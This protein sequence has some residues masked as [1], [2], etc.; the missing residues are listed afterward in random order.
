MYSVPSSN[1]C[2]TQFTSLPPNTGV[3]LATHDCFQVSSS[4]L[5]APNTFGYPRGG[6]NHVEPRLRYTSWAILAI[7]DIAGPKPV[8]C[9]LAVRSKPTL[10][11]IRNLRVLWNNPLRATPICCVYLASGACADDR[12]GRRLVFLGWICP[13]VFTLWETRL[14]YA[15]VSRTEYCKRPRP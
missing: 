1:L 15:P 8:L 10:P 6:A 7:G 14:P 4:R 11:R 5:S 12:S 9:G 13:S 3:L 2:S